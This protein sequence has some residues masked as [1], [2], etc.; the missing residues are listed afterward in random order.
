MVKLVGD[1]NFR[2]YSRSGR[3]A[4]VEGSYDAED[5][6][7]VICRHG[8]DKVGGSFVVWIWLKVAPMDEE[9]IGEPGKDT[10]KMDGIGS[11]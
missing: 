9:T 4:W 2:A 8:S 3:E 11:A 7:S 1:E 5:A 6:A 10:V